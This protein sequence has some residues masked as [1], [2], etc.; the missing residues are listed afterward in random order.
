[1]GCRTRA[2]EHEE[3]LTQRQLQQNKRQQ[4]AVE[5]NVVRKTAAVPSAPVRINRKKHKVTKSQYKALK[6]QK[7]RMI[8]LGG[9]AAAAVILLCGM[10]LISMDIND[11]LSK[12]IAG[13]EDQID[14]LEVYNDA[15]AYEIDSSLDIN[16]V[17][18]VATEELGMVRGSASQIVTYSTKNSEYLQQV[19]AVPTE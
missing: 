1:M 19:A 2:N 14:E 10:T 17:I 13:I 3:R 6:H 5:G 12:E 16:E 9:I 8:F 7:I 18:R 11:Q 4:N 15:R